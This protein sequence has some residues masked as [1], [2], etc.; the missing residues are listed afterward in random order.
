MD[1]GTYKALRRSLVLTK[2]AEMADGLYALRLQALED[3]D[4]EEMLG[5][6]DNIIDVEFE[7]D[8]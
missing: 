5:D 4:L 8:E 2:L 1:K 3:A 7:E 6:D